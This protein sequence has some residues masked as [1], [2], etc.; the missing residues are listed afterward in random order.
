MRTER[1]TDRSSTASLSRLPS[2]RD[3]NFLTFIQATVLPSFF[4]VAKVPMFQVPGMQST[5]QLLTW[6]LSAW[7]TALPSVL[8]VWAVQV[9]FTWVFLPH[10][11]I[12]TYPEFSH[13]IKA[14]ILSRQSR[15]E[16]PGEKW[17]K[18]MKQLL[19]NYKQADASKISKDL[20]TNINVSLV[21][22]LIHC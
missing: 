10:I 12:Y 22:D 5:N 21:T 14:L 7:T 9:N 13:P 11:Y 4:S 8:G 20:T 3:L 2:D 17:A 1:P 18:E 16:T 6:R 19:T 15:L